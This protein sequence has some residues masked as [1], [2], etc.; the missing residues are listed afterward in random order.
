MGRELGEL[1]D[2]FWSC[3]DGVL[4]GADQHRGVIGM[5]RIKSLANGIM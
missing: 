4:G 3:V 1:G 5:H 2:V